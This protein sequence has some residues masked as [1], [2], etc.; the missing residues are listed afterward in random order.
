VRGL[1]QQG[2]PIIN[3]AIGN[4]DL[5]P[6]QATI[7]A[8]NHAA[9]HSDSHGYQP[10]RGIPQLREAMSAYYRRTYGVSL[11]PVSEILPLMGS[12]EGIFHISMAFLNP[13]D[14]VLV[15]DPG[16]LAYPATA[17]IAGAEPLFYD[18]TAEKGWLPDIDHLS[19]L[20]LSGVKLMWIN[21]P[22]MPTGATASKEDFS[23]MAGFAR[24]HGILL[25]HDNPYSRILNDHPQSL[26]K[27]EKAMDCCLEL[28]SLSKSHNM[29]GWRMG[30]LCGRRDY[31]DTV[32]KVKSNI[33]SGQFLPLQ[34]AAIEALQN[35][36][37]WHQAQNL[38]YR[39][40]QGLVHQLLEAMGCSFDNGGAGMFVWAQ[41]PP[42]VHDVEAYVDELL[43]G[44]DI[45]IAPGS[46]F[47]KNGQA[48]VRVSLCASESSLKEALKR[49]SAP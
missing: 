24:R 2:R 49:V 11:D 4:P 16:Y 6:S 17:R 31:L 38:Q 36:D 35:D 27:V 46:I 26:L 47:G 33:D 12:K 30:M 15:P 3:L 25:C 21:Y 44:K 37:G 13:G 28:N 29:A 22:H 41:T 39:R 14:R 19:Q 42:G 5:P 48:Y 10:Y 43:Y 1:I 40:R 8:L 20:D 34:L 7:R 9:E 32:L 23:R 45:F 18:L